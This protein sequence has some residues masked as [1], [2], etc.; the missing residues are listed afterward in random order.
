MELARSVVLIGGDIQRRVFPV[1]DPVGKV[2]KINDKNFTVIGVLADKGSAFGG[3]RGQP[4]AGA[5]H[6]L[7]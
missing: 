4:G 3:S 2:I 5:D 7:F 6:P 1:E